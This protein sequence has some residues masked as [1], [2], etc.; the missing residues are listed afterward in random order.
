MSDTL[1][2]LTVRCLFFFSCLYQSCLCSSLFVSFL[3]GVR[4][5]I[6]EFV[7]FSLLF[8]KKFSLLECSF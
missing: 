4:V 6:E 3:H 2:S 8:D 5:M 1:L 7:S